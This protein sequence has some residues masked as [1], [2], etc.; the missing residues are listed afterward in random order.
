MDI[1]NL[2]ET[3]LKALFY[4]E[5]MKKE[6]AEMNLRIINEALAK[7]HSQSA[8]VVEEDKDAE[9]ETPPTE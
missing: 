9:I 6:Q 5:L 1:A 8:S 2:N 4:D 7:L 3:E